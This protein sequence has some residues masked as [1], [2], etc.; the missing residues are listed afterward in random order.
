MPITET[1][2]VMPAPFL[3]LFGRAGLFVSGMRN[4]SNSTSLRIH[5]SG[6]ARDKNFVSPFLKHAEEIFQTAKEGGLDDCEMSILVSREGNIHMLAGA[7]WELEPLR[8]HHGARAAYRIS[9]K[10]GGVRLEARSADES[11]LL[12]TRRP[13]RL[14]PA[15]M[16]D[17]PQYLTIQ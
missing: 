5:D 7:D 1:V 17:F 11:C 10:S 3:T 2:F 9:R 8:R 15:L 4:L 13:T 14:L 16:P 12:Q 6:G